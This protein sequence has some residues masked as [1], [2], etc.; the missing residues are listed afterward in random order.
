MF[1]ATREQHCKLLGQCDIL[2]T[3]KFNMANLLDTNWT[4]KQPADKEQHLHFK[5]TGELSHVH[6]TFKFVSVPTSS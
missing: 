6:P 5:Q 1:L 2:L 4:L 3:F